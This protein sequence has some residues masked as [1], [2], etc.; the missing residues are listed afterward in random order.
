VKQ[1]ARQYNAEILLLHVCESCVCHSRDG[2][3]RAGH[4]IRTRVDS[5]KHKPRRWRNSLLRSYAISKFGCLIYE[6]DPEA[7]IVAITEAEA[8]QLVI[9]LTHGYGVFRKSLFGSVTFK[10]LHN[11]GCPVLTGRTFDRA[12]RKSRVG[13]SPSHQC[14]SIL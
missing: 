6:G 14:M 4:G 13:S 10:V 12:K 2:N 9:M 11:L 5:Y 8:V 1:F 7:Q 3:F